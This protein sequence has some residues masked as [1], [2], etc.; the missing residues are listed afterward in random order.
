MGSSSYGGDTYCSAGTPSSSPAFPSPG[1]SV[2][3]TCLGSGGGGNSPQCTATLI[4][5]THRVTVTRTVG[6]NVTSSDGII[7]CGIGVNCYYDYN[8][9][10]NVTLTARPNSSYWKFNGWTGDCSG[11]SQCIISNIVSPKSIHAP[12]GLRLFRYSEF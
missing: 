5:T 6:G 11:T 1:Q 4:Q 2:N 3:W 12:F 9:G 7:N 8:Q 10:S